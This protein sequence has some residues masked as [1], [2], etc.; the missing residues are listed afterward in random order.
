MYLI[1][2]FGKA[3]EGKILSSKIAQKGLV[4]LFAITSLKIKIFSRFL[5]LKLSPFNAESDAYFRFFVPEKL[6]PA[7]QFKVEHPILHYLNEGSIFNPGRFWAGVGTYMI[8]K[9]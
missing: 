1:R 7:E 6:R 2:Q 4:L 3:L 5:C 9:L 8:G